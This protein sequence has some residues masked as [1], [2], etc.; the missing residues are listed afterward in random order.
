MI[1]KV[2]SY[3]GS[4]K[5]LPAGRLGLISSPTHKTLALVSMIVGSSKTAGRLG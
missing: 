4:D 1:A 3:L 5:D 2:A